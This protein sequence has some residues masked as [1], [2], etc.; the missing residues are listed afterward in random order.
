MGFCGYLEAECMAG[1]KWLL[2]EQEL[3]VL[4]NSVLVACTLS[5]FQKT[6]HHGSW[7]YTLYM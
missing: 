5:G 7:V 6:H 3:A 1:S 4:H 2:G